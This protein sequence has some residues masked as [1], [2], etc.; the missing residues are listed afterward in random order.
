M[1]TRN[2]DAGR[3][4]PT[5]AVA[6]ELSAG[7]GAENWNMTPELQNT[8]AMLAQK[9]GTSVEHLWPILVAKTKIDAGIGIIW[10]GVLGFTMALIAW[11]A[12]K[13]LHKKH[14]F[15]SDAPLGWGLLMA[16]TGISACVLLSCAVCTIGDFIY[17][18][19]AAIQGLIHK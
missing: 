10:M 6:S 18:E 1:E 2:Q 8:L 16:I 13:E 7:L 9:L 15:C 17:P 3:G 12:F 14:D 19:A 5:V 11:Q 4:C